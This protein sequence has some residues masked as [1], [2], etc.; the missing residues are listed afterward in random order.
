[1]LVLEMKTW[2]RVQK[3]TDPLP[4]GGWRSRH[5]AGYGGG[6]V[7]EHVAAQAGE[8]CPWC[9]GA[10]IFIPSNAISN[11]VIV[12]PD[13][14]PDDPSH[15]PAA[16]YCRVAPG[17]AAARSVE[18]M[19]DLLAGWDIIAG[20]DYGIYQILA[21]DFVLLE[22]EGE[23]VGEMEDGVLLDSVTVLRQLP[24]RQWLVEVAEVEIE[25]ED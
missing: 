24:I 25:E 6:V 5:H 13:C 8:P 11:L 14:S 17:V 16:D 4:T 19:L 23:V 10:T 2:W 22:L 3:S 20:V 18:H 7:C 9:G 12:C 15:L 1:M 21:S